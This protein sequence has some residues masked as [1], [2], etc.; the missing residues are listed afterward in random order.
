MENMDNKNS[1]IRPTFV[2]TLFSTLATLVLITANILAVIFYLFSLR[3]VY[4]VAPSFE[5]VWVLRIAPIVF[6]LL[7]LLK[8]FTKRDAKHLKIYVI[9]NIGL[10]LAMIIFAFFTSFFALLSGNRGFF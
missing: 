9:L 5:A 7:I 6:I 3:L 1:K 4:D 8:I 2:R 10:I